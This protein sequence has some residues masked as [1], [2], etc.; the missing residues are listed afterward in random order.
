MESPQQPSL[1]EV[2]GKLSAANPNSSE[3]ELCSSCSGTGWIR[4]GDAGV[5]RC[6]CLKRRIA[7]E[8]IRTVLQDWP[9]FGAARLENLEPQN[10][11]QRDGLKA[12]RINP[13][14]SY[15][16]YGDYG[17]GKT[18][19]MIAQYCYLAERGEN[20]LLRSPKDLVRELQKAETEEG[21]VSEVMQSARRAEKFHLFWDDIEKAPTYTTWR[22]EALRDLLDLIWR[23][24][25]RLTITS[26]ESM[27]GL[28]DKK[29]ISS[30]VI[31]RLF[32]ICT[33]VQ[34]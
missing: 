13:N 2:Q 17:S 29:L 28:E 25:L 34:V 10:L 5:G 32:R 22:E 33:P 31:S 4:Y 30:P 1:E 21:F 26:N 24:N 8:R 9:K 18:H 16:I 11:F 3:T 12:I 7:T 27:R 23:R 19:L 20:C 14:G 6:E 15:F